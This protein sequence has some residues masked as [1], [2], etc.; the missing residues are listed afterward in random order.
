MS[1]NVYLEAAFRDKRATFSPAQCVDPEEMDGYSPER[2]LVVTTGSQAEPR[3]MLSRAAYNGARN[4]KLTSSDLLLY[5]A[6][7]IPGN[8][9][10]IT[11][12]LNAIAQ[13]GPEIAMARSENLHCSGHA[14]REELLE[15]LRLV[16]PQH[17]LPVHGEYVFLKEHEALGREAGVKH[18]AVIRNGQML[19]VSPLRSGR[20]FG[21]L[22]TFQLLGEARLQSMY[23]DGNNGSGTMDDLALEDRRRLA[24]EGLVVATLKLHRSRADV[25]AAIAAGYQAPPRVSE[26]QMLAEE[27]E[28]NKLY[29]REPWRLDRDERRGAK[30][31]LAA[32]G[33]NGGPPLQGSAQVTVRAMYTGPDGSVTDELEKIALEAIQ[34]CSAA[35]EAWE[36]ERLVRKLL[37]Q[38]VRRITQR[39]PEVIVNAVDALTPEQLAEMHQGAPKAPARRRRTSRSAAG[40]AAAQG[41]AG[42]SREP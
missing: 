11:K 39:R 31:G 33:Q 1:L 13:C 41:G 12:M 4:L 26:A 7:M 38:G 23:N 29:E 30:E 32:S 24:F 37:M 35:A 42:G 25:E 22:G 27:R 34:S 18:T 15:V 10:R 20:Q 16:R 2:L 40:A 8:E 9:K 28:L 21:R 17:F 19:G 3:A 36:V 5:S 14:C 6:K